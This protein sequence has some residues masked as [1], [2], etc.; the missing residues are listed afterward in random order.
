MAAAAVAHAASEGLELVRCPHNKSGFKA[1]HHS[2]GPND[3]AACG[4][5]GRYLAK[6][7]LSGKETCIGSFQTPQEAALACAR[8]LKWQSGKTCGCYKCKAAAAAPA[9]TAAAPLSEAE[10]LNI[11]ASEGLTLARADT[12]TAFKYVREFKVGAARFSI[13][14]DMI[15][16]LRTTSP[17]IEEPGPFASAAEAALALARLLGREGSA[18]MAE[19]K[20]PLTVE[21]L[22]QK[23]QRTDDGNAFDGLFGGYECERCFYA[24][25]EGEQGSDALPPCGALY[26][27]DGHARR[28]GRACCLGGFAAMRAANKMGADPVAKGDRGYDGR[29]FVWQPGSGEGT[30][31]EGAGEGASSSEGGSGGSSG[32][33]GCY[34]HHCLWRGC[35]HTV[36][37]FMQYGW[38]GAARD[39]KMVEV[40]K[41]EAKV[42][43]DMPMT[44][45]E[46]DKA[47][48]PQ[49]VFGG[50]SFGPNLQAEKVITLERDENN[51]SG[52]KGVAM[53]REMNNGRPGAVKKRFTCPDVLGAFATA[54]ECALVR[55]KKL[56][57]R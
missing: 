20:E 3:V 48:F 49:M 22:E 17:D 40:Y 31:G 37:G 23:L 11:A 25:L 9:A 33:G 34:V 16:R 50:L 43:G 51:L 32:A 38:D 36:S 4:A 54:E 41:H 39:P 13:Q 12:A 28:G 10:V 15:A 21:E 52:F 44:K 42:H 47:C 53:N 57:R 35:G 56:Q 55:A 46:V 1:V 27:S 8:K 45:G 26:R 6:P 29:R 30:S 2:C 18:E 24:E 19:I 5:G 7:R 14:P